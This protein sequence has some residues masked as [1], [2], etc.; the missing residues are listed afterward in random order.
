MKFVNIFNNRFAL[1][2]NVGIFFSRFDKQGI[3]FD[4]FLTPFRFF[5]K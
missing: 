4:F 2:R 3:N 5:A 1:L